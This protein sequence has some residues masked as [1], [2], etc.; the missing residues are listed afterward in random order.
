[1]NQQ[2]LLVRL[3]SN[4]VA[5]TS[6]GKNQ[7]NQRK[8]VRN[9]LRVQASR[10]NC[11]RRRSS[12][13]TTNSSSTHHGD[14]SHN[15]NS[16]SNNSAGLKMNNHHL[17][18]KS[19]MTMTSKQV[20]KVMNMKSSNNNRSS[21]NNNSTTRALF[22]PSGDSSQTSIDMDRF[23]MK[24][25]DALLFKVDQLHAASEAMNG[26]VL[27]TQK[28]L[29]QL[30]KSLMEFSDDFDDDD[31][32]D[33]KMM[34]T[35]KILQSSTSTSSSATTM[36][37]KTTITNINDNKIKKRVVDDKQLLLIDDDDDSI[38][39][40]E[41][42]DDDVDVFNNNEEDDSMEPDMVMKDSNVSVGG[43]LGVDIS[44]LEREFDKLN[45][46]ETIKGK[47]EKDGVLPKNQRL[48]RGKSAAVVRTERSARVARG[49]RSHK[50]SSSSQKAIKIANQ[51]RDE[52]ADIY[53]KV[54]KES[55]RLVKQMEDN[56]W[57]S[58]DKRKK[59]PLLARKATK[60]NALR[61]ARADSRR[62]ADPN[63]NADSMRV[64]LKDIGTV[65]LLNGS[66]EVELARKIQDL[67]RLELIY[68]DLVEKE[69]EGEDVVNAQAES[70]KVTKMMWAREVGL[71]EIELE[72]RLMIGKDAKNHMIQAN[73]RLVVSIAKRY[74]NRNMSFQDLIQEGCVGLIRG[75]EK[76]DFERGYKFSTY[77][78]WWI[79]QAVTRSISDQSRT[80]R[81]PVHLFE[82]ISRMSK[83]EQQFML[84]SGRDPTLSELGGLM[85]MSEAKVMQIKKA[86]LAPISLNKH[87][88]NGS[89]GQGDK[90]TVEDTLVDNTIEHPEESSGKVLLKEDLE[91]VLNTLNPRERD[92]LRLRYGL[93]DGRVK[94]LEEIGNV[95]SVTR[96]RIRQIEAKALRKLRQPSRNSILRDYIPSLNCL[97]EMEIIGTSG[98]DEDREPENKGTYQHQKYPENSKAR[99]DGLN[100]SI[101]A[102]MPKA[103]PR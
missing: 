62:K 101:G 60:A 5:S 74:S 40:D 48:L 98:E 64:Y 37:T 69:C 78:H 55:T 14:L 67:M 43:A 75:A 23:D 32:D 73:L 11:R 79:R 30:E 66:Q 12:F 49:V 20:G 36:K 81:L 8:L 72:E 22:M 10:E 95:F 47:K 76:F 44:A 29:D 1:M 80:I 18:S 17:S 99:F 84:Q 100:N 16:N 35:K 52:S 13:I 93:D 51:D 90:R 88:G 68:K 9:V 28:E 26:G 31:G 7:I 85:E 96:E 83:V 92:V 59:V 50:N 42:D 24:D 4:N 94:T 61:E 103:S 77:A 46:K 82:I 86:A 15:S 97:E 19:M 6:T 58:N 2:Q 53:G 25:L 63:G 70:G 3:A 33:K 91:N 57:A 102:K 45:S 56:M 89:D 27:P 87:V 65:S 71:T 34:K 39:F 54:T 21:R 41:D 38:S